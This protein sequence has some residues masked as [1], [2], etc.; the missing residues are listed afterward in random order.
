MSIED[1]AE[2]TA[3]ESKPKGVTDVGAATDS[4]I[5]QAAM[6]GELENTPDVNSFS[7]DGPVY[8]TSDLPGDAETEVSNAPSE[9]EPEPRTS[10]AGE[11]LFVDNSVPGSSE[12]ETAV[13]AYDIEGARA[14]VVLRTTTY[15]HR[16]K[17]I[18]AE[19]VT[20]VPNT[21]VTGSPTLDTPRPRLRMRS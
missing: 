20:Y 2:T 11:L 12:Y 8:E 5:N 6:V 14:G 17:E 18:I 19:N 3:K 9:P 4:E 21:K 15:H 1:T 16:T 10:A 7:S 13:V